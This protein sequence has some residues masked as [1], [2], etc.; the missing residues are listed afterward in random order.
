MCFVN[1]RLTGFFRNVFYLS[2]HSFVC[3]SSVSVCGFWDCSSSGKNNAG[4][5]CWH[6]SVWTHCCEKIT[7][8][9][10]PS[11]WQPAH[12]LPGYDDGEC[13]S[14]TSLALTLPACFF[15]CFPQICLV[16]FLPTIFFWFGIFV[17]LFMPDLLSFEFFFWLDSWL[18]IFTHEPFSC[19][20]QPLKCHKAGFPLL[21]CLLFFPGLI[22]PFSFIF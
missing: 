7:L 10:L 20:L 13:S 17:H 1:V 21:L 8:S 6:K 9:R 18:L 16:Q 5:P 19:T 2:G 3:C 11:P 22:F 14:A 15:H 4:F 12:S